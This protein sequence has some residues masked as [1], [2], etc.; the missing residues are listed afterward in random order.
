MM[1]EIR[2]EDLLGRRVH[3]SEGRIAGHVEEVVARKDGRRLVVVE[4]RLGAYALLHRLA[5]GAFGRRLLGLLPM[6]RPAAYR[7]PW[8]Q[9]DLSDLD[10]LRLRCPRGDL[11]KAA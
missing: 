8:E 9:L 5:G 4:Y 10:R 1:V 2:L 6:T 11:R 3:D 7:V